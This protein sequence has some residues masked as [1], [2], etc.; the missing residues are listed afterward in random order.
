MRV[1][2]NRV[3][4]VTTNIVAVRIALPV[5]YG[6]EDMPNN[7][8]YR[9][10]DMW[11]VVINADTGQI[12]NWPAGVAH[13][14]HMKVTDGGT[15]ELLNI[16]GRVVLAIEENYVPHGVIPGEYG[17]YVILDIGPDGVI[18][19]W[20]KRFDLSRDPWPGMSHDQD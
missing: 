17:D 12:S 11:S 1:A 10:G 18:R 16:D 5:K 7:F 6:E 19:N 2:F 20:P 14:L 3:E 4:S 15:Y 9:H 13:K 8:P